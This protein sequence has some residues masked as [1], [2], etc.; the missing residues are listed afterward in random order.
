MPPLTDRI[1]GICVYNKQIYYTV[2]NTGD[3]VAPGKIRRVDLNGTGAIVPSTDVEILTVPGSTTMASDWGTV[4]L[5]VSDI[6]ISADGKT[7]IFGQRGQRDWGGYLASTNHPGKVFI[8]TLTGAVWS[9]IK[10]IEP[11]NSW[12]HGE[13][14]GGLDWGMENGG[15]EKI[16]WNSSADL[17]GGPGP[18]GLQAHAPQTF[19]SCPPS[20][21]FVSKC[22]TIR[23]HHQRTGLERHRR[24]HRHHAGR[25]MHGN[26]CEGYPLSRQGGRSVHCH[27]RCH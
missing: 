3:T 10:G 25:R 8:A 26:R 14:Y 9:V 2:W 16:I 4:Q 15:Q 20:C 19:S 5:P 23:L 24:R 7:M 17:A 27:P 18:H 21:R 22:R 6:E 13:G 11:G 1:W 12:G